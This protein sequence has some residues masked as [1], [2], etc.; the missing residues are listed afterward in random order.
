MRKCVSSFYKIYNQILEFEER[1][2]QA[3]KKSETIQKVL[4][5]NE[6]I[7]EERKN[8][9]LNK[10]K[11]AEYRKMELQKLKQK[12]IDF[13][14]KQLEEKEKYRLEVLK[15]NEELENKEKQRIM[16]KIEQDQTKFEKVLHERQAF[17]TEKKEADAQ[18]RKERQKNVRKIAKMQENEK[19]AILERIQKDDQRAEQIKKEK[20]QLYDIRK[21]MRIEADRMKEDMMEYL[22]KIDVNNTSLDEA[23]T[24]M[25]KFSYKFKEKYRS[26]IE[27]ANTGNYNSP[28][29]SSAKFYP[30]SSQK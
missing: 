8:E 7:E 16:K 12:E 13:K 2:K 28:A 1:R 27:A 15:H 5:Q 6:K 14:K 23:R 18:K 19:M 29:H 10:E 9:I 30:V 24:L 20:A 4:Q 11:E 21:N 25:D 17:L 26:M 3:Q 22:D